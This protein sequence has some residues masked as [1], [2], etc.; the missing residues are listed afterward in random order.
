MAFLHPAIFFAGLAAISAPIL[1]HLLFR[2]RRRPVPWAAMRFLVAAVRRQR[3]RLRL[4]QFLLLL[5]RAA[6]IALVA[7][8]LA[9]PILGA[10]PLGARGRDLLLVLDDS[11]ASGLASASG[12]AELDDTRRAVEALAAE[13]DPARGDRVTLLGLARP[14]RPLAPAPITD[15]AEL[16]RITR[17]LEPSSAPPDWT[18][19]TALARG[20]LGSTDPARARVVVLAGAWRR[21]SIDTDRPLG[22]LID[23]LAAAAPPSQ[24]PPSL[25]A[26]PAPAQPGTGPGLGIPILIATAPAT[27]PAAT[28]SVESVVPLRALAVA[29]D[30]AGPGGQVRVTLRRKGDLDTLPRALSRV[31]LYEQRPDQPLSTAINPATSAPPSPASSGPASSSPAAPFFNADTPVAEATIAWEPGET[32]QTL[33]LTPSR[34]EAAPPGRL[35]YLAR[36]ETASDRLA[37]DDFARSAAEIRGAVRVGLI[38]ASRLG[39]GPA[40]YGPADWV[41]FALRPSPVLAQA[42]ELVPIDPA[43]ADPARLG[44]LD[45]AFVLEPDDLRAQAWPELKR[46]LD[47]GGLVVIAPAAEPGAQRWPELASELLGPGVAINPTPALH[48]EPLAAEPEPAAAADGPLALI[49]SELADL[50]AGVRVSTSLS[51]TLDPSSA[52][53]PLIRLADGSP[54]LAVASASP[55]APSPDAPPPTATADAQTDPPPP[56]SPAPPGPEPQAIA[57]RPGTLALL[58]VA[59]VIEWSDLPARPV[60][61]PL[62]QELLKQGL[63]LGASSPPALA[64]SHLPAPAGA[65]ELIGL[66]RGEAL[67]IAQDRRTAEPVRRAGAWQARSPDGSDLGV[68][69]ANPAAQAADPGLL[70]AD[71]L[72]RWL[73]PWAGERG[74]SWIAPG[75]ENAQP[76]AARSIAAAIGSSSDRAP[77]DWPLLVAAALLAVIEAGLARVASHAER[78][79]HT[80]TSSTTPS[81]LAPLAPAPASSSGAR[82]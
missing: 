39:G 63:A 50:I 48:Q 69:I 78:E 5:A 26:T 43:D 22:P 60:F 12:G 1:I 68:V 21:G 49:A 25:P 28:V 31:S 53:R 29:S 77:F 64:G 19:L 75:R 9:R 70:P 13:L 38:A 66:D 71:D 59:P 8:A 57:R 32:T 61:V 2:R 42:I 74:L 10:G 51:V 55:S 46:L 54:L 40:A 27:D 41:G 15:P 23:A 47:R 7:A 67:P 35:I 45:A 33:T 3:R 76:L 30:L 79:A 81:P 36:V 73:G 17:R 24:P 34:P 65:T 44:A 82:R 18:G 62:M 14:A 56:G 16:L 72:A 6:L 80:P 52:L 20:W 37:A 11:I 58:T 4:E